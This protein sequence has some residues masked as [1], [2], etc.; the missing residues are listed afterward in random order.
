MVG[1]TVERDRHGCF[2]EKIVEHP[3]RDNVSLSKNDPDIGGHRLD[4]R[5]E[6]DRRQ[7]LAFGANQQ[8]FEFAVAGNRQTFQLFV[9]ALAQY[10]PPVPPELRFA[11]G[12]QFRRFPQAIPLRQNQFNGPCIQGDCQREAD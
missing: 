4:D 10:G 8:R 3:G 1:R 6:F 11:V 7:R 2:A 12:S 9:P 5:L